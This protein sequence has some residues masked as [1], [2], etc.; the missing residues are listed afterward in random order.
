MA[1]RE[2]L[3]RRE[4]EPPDALYVQQRQIRRP[5]IAHPGNA[6]RSRPQPVDVVRQRP[7]R[8]PTQL[9]RVDLPAE[10][11]RIDR[12]RRET[13]H[14]PKLSALRHWAS[15][16]MRP[17]TRGLAMPIAAASGP[18]APFRVLDLTDELGHL[19]GRMLAELGADVIK[20]EP[21]NGGG[22]RL[23]PPFYHDEPH[24]ERSLLWWTLNHSKRSITIDL[25]KPR[26]AD[27]FF[28]LVDRSDFIVES[29]PPGAMESVGLGWDLI[30][31]RNPRL[32]MTSITP[33]GQDGPYAELAS[34]RPDRR[35]DG[36]P[37]LTL[38]LARPAADPALRRA[39]LHAGLCAGRGRHDDRAL[40]PHP[41]GPRPARRPVDAGGR[42][43]HA[44]QRDADLGHPRDQH[45]PARQRTQ[46]RR[47]SERAVRLRGGRRARR[48]ALLRRAVRPDRAPDG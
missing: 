40:P 35:R 22:S 6:P 47:L 37:R 17:Q 42:H 32:V 34:H 39:G 25:S 24:P 4:L 43:V 11:D 3:R 48:G 18:L 30:H 2:R 29:T 31:E 5:R 45:R 13:S 7:G 33:F 1:L 27:L 26:G 23:A 36:R 44:R 28:Q 41:H 9:R 19:A 21:P 14:T 20:L 16:S 10:E 15:S 12:L 8:A 38:R 46:H